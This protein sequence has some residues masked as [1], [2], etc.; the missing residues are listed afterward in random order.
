MKRVSN[1]TVGAAGEAFLDLW[2]K[3]AGGSATEPAQDRFGWD[4]Y[5]EFDS[6][7]DGPLLDLEAT[8]IAAYIQ[9]KTTTKAE[10]FMTQVSLRN[11]K[12]AADDPAPFFFLFL[13]LS[14]NGQ[15]IIRASLTHFG[16]KW[17]SLT[18]KQI[19][20]AEVLNQTSWRRKKI[21][22]RPGSS[23]DLPAPFG[24]S[25]VNRLRR[26]IS[27]PR[28]YSRRKA[29]AS[30]SLGYGEFRESIEVSFK[31]TS[32]DEPI[33]L[34]TSAALG[35]KVRIAATSITVRDLRFDMPLVARRD[36]GSY[37]EISTEGDPDWILELSDA[38]DRERSVLWEMSMFSTASIEDLVPDFTPVAVLRNDFFEIR[39]T[40]EHNDNSLRLT[41]FN[42]LQAEP[43][44]SQLRELAETYRILADAKEFSIRVKPLGRPTT[45][46]SGTTSM[47]PEQQRQNL[48]SASQALQDF[49]L[50][51][52][53]SSPSTDLTLPVS[54]LIAIA[55][56][57]SWFAALEKGQQ[58]YVR[59]MPIE[60]DGARVGMRVAAAPVVLRSIGNQHLVLSLLV[61]GELTEHTSG[62]LKL[63]AVC[64]KL[65]RVRL[66]PKSLLDK[67]W[68]VRMQEEELRDAPEDVSKIVLI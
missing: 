40:G 59:L 28:E 48:R 53:L 47:P 35:E 2:I 3:A 44:I 4:R 54:D 68:R 36:L 61:V 11:L 42:P 8:K 9:V 30:Q 62:R 25:L 27:D 66:V 49:Y 39:F 55:S 57:L 24:S 22:I 65:G 33:R 38:N 13:Q 51:S 20:Q 21:T 67:D 1:R 29:T 23:D 46:L 15:D 45:H 43:R 5:V 56:D 14:S 34:L 58:I 50:L 37:F 10:S 60:F 63:D 19:R 18:L 26:D 12:L 6:V 41:A 7:P 17:I 16:E 52:R 32:K 31:T 64:N